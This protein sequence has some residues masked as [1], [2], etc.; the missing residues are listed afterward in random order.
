MEGS[1]AS[2]R[3]D[4]RPAVCAPVD[5]RVRAA[6]IE[7]LAERLPFTANIGGVIAIL[8][9]IGAWPAVGGVGLAVWL[10]CVVVT[11]AVRHWSLGRYRRDPGRRQRTAYW[12]VA[13]TLNAFSSGFLWAVFGLLTFTPQDP[14]HMLFVAIVLIGLTAASLAS[15]SAWRPAHFAFAIPTMTG[16]IVTDA[17]SGVTSLMVLAAMAVMF[18]MVNLLSA[19]SAEAALVESIR[20]RFDNTR[21]IDEL[22]RSRADLAQVL[23]AAADGICGVDGL[24]RVSFANRAAADLTGWPSAREMVGQDTRVAFGHLLA[25]GRPCDQGVCAIGQTVADGVERRITGESFSR[26][27]GPRFPVEY[28][29]SPLHE[30]GAL[31]G[32]VV[33]FH[34][35]GERLAAEQAL[36]ERQEFFEQVFVGGSAIKLV[37]DPADGRLVDANPAAAEFYG[38]TVEALRSMRLA[39]IAVATPA[40]IA[41]QLRRA[42]GRRQSY[43][44][45]EHRLID[46]TVRSV[47]VYAGP[48]RIKDRVLL[49][50]IIHDVTD[51]VRNERELAQAR[52]K[53][54]AQAAELARSNAELEQFATVASHDL[55]QPLRQVSSFLGMLERHLGGGLDDQAREFLGFAVD[56]A[57]RMDRLIVDLL[58]YSRIGRDTMPTDSV[59]LAEAIGDAVRSLGLE[60]EESGATVTIATDLP[61]VTGDRGEL[62]R[63]FQNLIGNAIKYRV[64][65]RPPVVDIGVDVA[66]AEV[67]T[68][69][70][71]N[72]IGIPAEHHQRIFSIFQRLHTQQEYEGT[73][74]GLAVCRKIVDRHGGRIWVESL[75]GQ[76][77][78]FHVALAL[79]GAGSD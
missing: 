8:A 3:D 35:V 79:A 45:A 32:A 43:F 38:H 51:R 60:I 78:A 71:D 58:Q 53:L 73:G 6:Q 34:D 64:P 37:I 36:R 42:E 9:T 39:E 44:R 31:A 18:L 15:L 72:G 57:K 23:D 16:F 62:A 75:P 68:T 22:A 21:L 61:V 47:E 20:L 12:G 66:G 49:M 69:V 10:G 29:V 4:S 59:R 17:L 19:R 52:G 76:G 40:E 25:D 5:E 7:I 13:L 14:A 55:R 26:R 65:N 41:D 24:M 33:V 56:G 63:L 67:V 50:A 46:T 30:G 11:V 2:T 28:V 70:R 1:T 74:I 77:A 27:D 48:C 54:Q